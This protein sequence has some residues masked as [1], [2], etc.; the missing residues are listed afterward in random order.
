MAIR[1][2]GTEL[3]VGFREPARLAIVDTRNGNL[4]AITPTCGDPD[5]IAVDEKRN[6]AY[7]SCGQG[8]IDVFQLGDSN[9]LR[10]ARIVTIVGANGTL[11][12]GTRPVFPRSESHLGHSCRHL[13]LQATRTL[14]AS[15][16][17]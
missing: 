8:F 11:R 6:R 1:Q 12:S 16:F 13:A 4:R 2:R 5:D 9:P 14:N 17:Y 3:L 7:V 10:I 15:I